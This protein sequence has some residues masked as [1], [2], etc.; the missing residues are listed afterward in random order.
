MCCST[1]VTSLIAR[2]AALLQYYERPLAITGAPSRAHLYKPHPPALQLHVGQPPPSASGAPSSSA[3]RLGYWLSSSTSSAISRAP[4]KRNG[5]SLWACHNEHWPT[6]SLSCDCQLP[7]LL[8]PTGATL[9]GA[10]RPVHARGHCGPL[11]WMIR[12]QCKRPGI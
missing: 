5:T 11:Q 6:T 2:S 3:L 9:T 10:L 7:H 4:N 1:I 8:L 12:C